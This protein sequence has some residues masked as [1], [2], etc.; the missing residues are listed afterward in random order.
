MCPWMRTKVRRTYALTELNLQSAL[1]RQVYAILKDRV[2]GHIRAY[3]PNLLTKTGMDVDFA[4]VWHVLGWEGFV[5]VDEHGAC[6]LTIQYLST[7]RDVG[8]GIM[9]R[10][11]RMEYH[12]SVK[13]LSLHLGFNKRC[14]VDLETMTLGVFG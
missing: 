7:L 2:F 9:F 11:F 6:F 1:E 4:N 14:S 5:L 13:N 8:D 10:F 12:L 3:D